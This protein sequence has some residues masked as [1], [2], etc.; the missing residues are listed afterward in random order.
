MNLEKGEHRQRVKLTKALMKNYRMLKAHCDSAEYNLKPK[1]AECETMPGLFVKFILESN[2]KTKYIMADIDKML[3][4]YKTSCG[5]SKKPEKARRWR[6]LEAAY[7]S[8]SG[9]S[10]EEIAE[11]ENIDRRTVSKD[12]ESCIRDLTV[13]FFG[14]DGLDEF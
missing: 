8:D 10:T 12:I 1:I 13:L 5:M 4:A 3:D 9:L 2:A 14:I 11:R 6:V 7:I